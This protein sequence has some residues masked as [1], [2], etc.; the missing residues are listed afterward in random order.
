[1]SKKKA[2]ANKKTLA[3]KMQKNKRIKNRGNTSAKGFWQLHTKALLALSALAFVLYVYSASFDYSLD[4][5]LYITGND[6]TKSGISGIPDIFSNESLVGFWGNKK[7]LEGGRYRPLGIA[8]YAL[9]YEL[10]GENPG[11]SHFINVLLYI[12]VGVLLYRL[13]CMLFPPKKERNWYFTIAFVIAAL[14]IVHPLHSEVVASVK[15]R[16]EILESIGVL[17]S[18]IFTMCYIKTE[19]VKWLVFSFLAFFMALLSKES[20]LTFVAIIPLMVYFFTKASVAK[21]A[22]SATPILAATALMFLIR[23]AVLGYFISDDIKP[24]QELLNNP[25]LY[26]TEA[27]RLATVFYTMGIYI[28]K[29]IFPITLTHDYYPKH[30]PIINWSDYRAILSLTVYLGLGAAA[31]WGLVKKNVYG[32]GILLYLLSFSIVSNLVINVGAFMNERFM[33]LPSLGFCIILGYFLV[34]TLPRYIKNKGTKAALICFGLLLGAYSV[35]TLARVPAW[36]SNET[37]FLTDVHNS[38]QSAKVTTSAGGTLV[39][40]ASAIRIKNNGVL[41]KKAGQDLIK[42]M[43]YLNKSLQIYPDNINALLL[44][45]NAHY[46]LN[47]NYKGM[48]DAYYEIL[49]RNPEYSQVYVNIEKVSVG[50]QDAKE[51]DIFIDFLENRVIPLNPNA[52][53]AYDV[54]GELYGKKKNNLAK[55]I[56]NFEK[57]IALDENHPGTLHDLGTAYGMTSQFDKSLEVSLKAIKNDP[58]NPKIL[59]NIATSYYNLGDTLKA[60]EY[61]KK[62]QIFQGSGLQGN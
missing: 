52:A 61:S 29:L 37:L 28:Q 12:L 43:E 18:M 56:E 30:I 13:L 19:Q 40:K 23:Y 9:E 60:Q 22:I 62:A 11:F 46:E 25:Y 55:A 48:F 5:K 39:E 16:I 58:Q 35:R 36:E 53:G 6:F 32:F 3:A 20:A 15:G 47:K 49:N 7:L 42:G 17:L 1:M 8:T 10:F 26:A 21:N 4:D 31:I 14:Y 27:E 38:P 41:T 54:L 24:P 34:E 51:A 2:T 44:L 45:G 59:R 57:V 50:V 33:Y